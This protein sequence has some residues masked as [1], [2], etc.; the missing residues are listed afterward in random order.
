[1]CQFSRRPTFLTLAL[2]IATAMAAT[3]PLPARAYTDLYIFGDSLSDTGN[4]DRFPY[5]LS[6]DLVLGP[7]ES[8][9]DGIVWHEYLSDSLGLARAEPSFDGGTNY[10]VGGARTDRSGTANVI[11]FPDTGIE[12][13][14]DDFISDL[15]PGGADPAALYV[16]WGGGN[17]MR[18]ATSPSQAAGPVANL[19]QHVRS[20]AAAGAT[21][22]IFPNLPNLGRTPE[23]IA[24]GPAAMALAEEISIAF[25]TGL[26][27]AADS[28]ESDLA[29]NLFRLDVFLA[30]EALSRDG[31]AFGFNNTT[32]VCGNVDGP[33]D[34]DLFWDE[35]HPTTAAH[36]LLGHGA[37]ATL[38][39]SPLGDFNGD[40]SVNLGDVPAFVQALTNRD[41]FEAQY[42]AVDPDIAGDIDNSGTFDLGDIRPFGAMFE[43]PSATAASVPEP[44][45]ALLAMAA[46]LWLLAIRTR[47]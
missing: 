7:T 29:V 34:G 23:S 16:V 32:V 1:M 45:A 25:N 24:D 40:D 35:I 12:A 22:I 21:D 37:Q 38:V 31:G 6:P 3:A 10:A 39:G 15:P 33:C 11:F 4:L 13:Q 19:E 27:L 28:I 2:A 14:V 46:G 5:N 20:L 41:L 42:P 43:P 18:D 9:S 47:C 17:D 30:M 26:A 36:E 44:R 8:F